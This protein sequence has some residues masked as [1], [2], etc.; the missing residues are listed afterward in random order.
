MK[1]KSSYASH[2]TSNTPLTNEQFSPALELCPPFSVGG[3]D[4]LT[5]SDDSLSVFS[6]AGKSAE[7]K[8]LILH[9]SQFLFRQSVSKVFLLM[10]EL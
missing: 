3:Y 10:L 2:Q 8:Y 7:L 9:L 1:H 6:S 5:C 4:F